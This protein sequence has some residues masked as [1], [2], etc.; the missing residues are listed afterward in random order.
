MPLCLAPQCLAA[1]AQ[2]CLHVDSASQPGSTGQ[3]HGCRGHSRGHGAIGVTGG[4]ARG[5]PAGFVLRGDLVSAC[6]GSSAGPW[7]AW[8]PFNVVTAGVDIDNGEIDA[9][10]MNVDIER[11]EL[12]DDS[13]DGGNNYEEGKE[14]ESDDEPSAE[15]EDNNACRQEGKVLQLLEGEKNLKS[16]IEPSS[17]TPLD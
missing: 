11:T 9:D 3:G 12:G 16:T 4:S 6:R 7:G 2:L 1:V 8:G 15:P 13:D 5:D 10:L 14:E 17:L